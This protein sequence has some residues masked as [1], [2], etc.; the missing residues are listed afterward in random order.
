[1]TSPLPSVVTKGTG[2]GGTLRLISGTILLLP[3]AT[4]SHFG[5][6]VSN[7]ILVTTSGILPDCIHGIA[8]PHKKSDKKWSYAYHVHAHKNTP[9]SKV[10]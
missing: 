3:V 8:L 4:L 10:C 6:M 7:L 2:G 1:M 5:T 9:L